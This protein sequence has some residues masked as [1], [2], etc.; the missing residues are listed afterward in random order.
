MEGA[1]GS[2]PANPALV[3]IFTRLVSICYTAKIQTVDEVRPPSPVCVCVAANGARSWSW[4]TAIDAGLGGWW[5]GWVELC[6]YAG[7]CK[8]AQG[9]LCYWRWDVYSFYWEWRRSIEM[10]DGEVLL[11]HKL[12]LPCFRTTFVLLLSSSRHVYWRNF[13][14]SR[15]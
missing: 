12:R 10:T 9:G 3:S 4:E 5:S 8:S 14:W 7:K 11:M 1:L 15:E 6:L 2:P 13:C